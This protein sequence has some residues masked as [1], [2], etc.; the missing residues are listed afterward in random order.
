MFVHDGATVAYQY[1]HYT[2]A[3]AYKDGK[4]KPEVA[5][6]NFVAQ[7]MKEGDGA[8]RMSRFTATPMP[9]ATKK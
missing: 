9:P 1:G 5:H 6:N 4:K 3:L 8:W 2:E 7:W